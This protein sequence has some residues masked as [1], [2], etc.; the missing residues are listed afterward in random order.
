MNYQSMTKAQLIAHL[1]KITA[2][3]EYSHV[4]AYKGYQ[5]GSNRDKFLIFFEK[6][7][8]G[9]LFLNKDGIITAVN[10]AALEIFGLEIDEIVGSTLLD[11]RWKVIH[12]DGSEFS[13]KEQPS[14]IALNTGREV[15]NVVAGVLNSNKKET[16]WI[17]M[18]AIPIY[19][20]DNEKPDEVF[21]TLHDITDH[22]S[23]NLKM[24]ENEERFRTF[25]EVSLD[26]LWATDAEGNNTY[27]SPSWCA[28]TSISEREAR[29]AGWSTGIHPEDRD[30]IFA[31]W[32][33][34][35]QNDQPYV[36][37]FR[38]VHPNGR[39]VW[40][41]CQARSIK[42]ANGSI[43]EWVGTITD[44][45]ERKQAEEKIK[46]N[47]E[48][49]ELLLDT[50]PECVAVLDEN[51]KIVRVNDAWKKFTD[52][53]E[54]PK[55]SHYYIGREYC[56]SKMLNS[57][58]GCE[59]DISKVEN[60]LK[61]LVNG[62][63]DQFTMEYPCHSPNEKR[64]FEMRAVP[65][66]SLK[67]DSREQ[68]VKG[69]LVMHINITNIK[70]AEIALMQSAALLD[71]TEKLSKVGGW[72]WNIDEQKM[73]WTEEVYHIHGMKSTDLQPGSNEHINR[74]IECYMPDDRKII[75]DA[76][77][78]CAEEGT[79]YDLEVPFTTVGGEK[80]W[81]RTTAQAV[82]EKGKIARVIGNI[83]DITDR[84]MTENALRDSEERLRLFIDHAP[85]ALAMF[86]PEMCYLAASKR[87]ISDYNLSE[88]D[89]IGKS[90]YELFP[91]IGDEWKSVHKR[92]L[93]GIIVTAEEDKFLLE[94]G[95]VQWLRWEVRPW[96]RADETV[97]GIVIF[98]E[99]IT[100]NI[101]SK[102][103]MASRL[104]LI[105]FA[106]NHT[107][108]ELLEETLNET[109][110]LTGSNIG[111]YHFVEKDQLSLTLQNWST[112][113]KEKFCKAESKGL[114][115]NID[116]AGVW[117]D[118][119]YQR[120]PVIH[121]DYAALNHKKGMPSGH[122]EVI[123][124]LVV[125]VLRGDKIAAI[126][127]VGNK[128]QDY[129]QKDVDIVALIADMAWDIVER[130][131]IEEVL[132]IS[133]DNLYTFFNTVDEFLFILDEEY[134]IIEFNETVGKRLGYSR[135]ELIGK[136][137][138]KVHPENRHKEAVEIVTAMLAGKRTS[139]P[140]PLV[141]KSGELIPVE[142]SVKLGKW[143]GSPA[144]F[145]A[146]KDI[147][148]LK[149]SEE[150]FATAFHSN[151]AIA[152]LSDMETGVY[153]E[154]NQTFYDKL[155]FS[156]DEVIGRRASEVVRLDIKFRDRTISKLKKNNFVNNEEAVIYAKDGTPID[157][158]L[159]A[160]II[161]LQG[162]R[163]NYTAAVDISERKKSELALRE[164]EARFRAIFKSVNEGIIYYNK[165]GTVLYVNETLEKITGI[166][167]DDLIG[168]NALSL[169]KK[170]V[171]KNQRLL[172]LKKLGSVLRGSSI[173]PFELEF[174]DKILEISTFYI[175]DTKHLTTIIRDI[176]EQKKYEI[177]IR[178]RE[179]NYRQV[180]NT[181]QETL[182]VISLDGS[183]LFANSNA[184]LNLS[185]D[186]P[187]TVIGKNISDF[188]PKSQSD[189][190]IAQY[191]QVYETGQSLT[192]DI[193][194]DIKKGTT[195]FYN[196]LKPIEYGMD[197]IPAILSVS[198]DITKE[199]LAEK[200]LRESEEKFRT[201]F[202]NANI[203]IALSDENGVLIE[204]NREFCAM[205]G[206]ECD[207]LRGRNVLEI[208]HPDDRVFE[209]NVF[210]KPVDKR[211]N[212]H[213]FIKR[214]LTRQNTI[215]WVDLS[216]F[217][218]YRDPENS[219]FIFAGMALDITDRVLA[220]QALRESEYRY[221]L[222]MMASTD[223]IYDWDLKTNQVYYSP[224][225]KRMLGYG[226]EEIR[227]ELSEWERLT[228]P[229]DVPRTYRM[230]EE[231]FSG[232]RDRAEIE[233]RM[234]HK[235]GHWVDI[236]TR[237]SAVFDE[238]GKPIRQVGTHL[239]ISGRKR[240]E[241]ALRRSELQYRQLFDE[242][243]T[244]F[245]LHEIICD[246][247]GKPIDY[248]YLSINRAAE[249][250]IGLKA[251]ELVNKR[252]LE[253]FPDMNPRMIDLLGKVALTGEGIEYQDHAIKED[254]YFDVRAF[255][256]EHG[257]FAII[258]ND[259]TDR[260]K[261]L[262]VLNEREAQL[263]MAVNMAKLGY[264]EY[265]VAENLFKFNDNF[266]KI[267][268]TSANEAGG[269]T[270]SP[271]EY[272]ERFM[273]PDDG[274]IVADET[275]KAIE[276]E[277]ADYSRSLEHRFL[278]ADGGIGYL[279][280]LFFV[281][282]DED[283]KTIKT[284]GVNQDI[285]DR[286]RAELALV[287]NE[288]KITTLIS[289]L[290]GMAYTCLNEKTWTMSFISEG[291]LA[292]TGY[293]PDEIIN[294]SSLSY[295]DLI[296]EEDRERIWDEVQAAL[297]HRKHFFLEYRI[298]TKSG[299]IKN[300]WEGGIGVFNN[301]GE[302]DALEGFIMDITPR[303]EMQ[304][305]LIESENRLRILFEMMV[306]GVVYHDADGKIIWANPAAEKILGVSLRTMQG[307]T[308]MD[309]QFNVIKEDGL[310]FPG[311]THPAMV[312]LRTGKPQNNV[313]MGVYNQNEE[314]YHWIDVSSMPLILPG[315]DKPYQVFATFTDITERLEAQQK[316]KYLNTAIE[317][318]T[319]S[320]VITETNGY[321][322]YCNPAVSRT[323]GYDKDELIGQHTRIFKSGKQNLE[324]YK[325]LWDIITN[326][327]TWSGHL[328]NKRK[329]GQFYHE[330]AVISP[331]HSPLGEIIGY[332]ALKRDVTR[333]VELEEQILQSQKLETLGILAGGIAHDFNNLLTLINGYSEFIMDR[334]GPGDPFYKQIQH[335]NNAGHRAARLTSQLLAFSRKQVIEPQI[336][337]LH[338]EIDG[339]RKILQRIIGEDIQ[340]E[341]HMNA[342][343]PYIKMDPGQLEQIIMN[344]SVNA[345]DAMQ[346]GGVFTIATSD[347]S[348]GD[349]EMAQF[350]GVQPGNYI[351]FSFSDTGVG[352]D[353]EIQKKIFE[354][355]FTTKGVGKGTGLGLAMV[356]GIVMQNN[357]QI[358]VVSKPGAGTTFH[359]YLPKIE[360]TDSVKSALLR[361]GVQYTY[362]ATILLVED[363]IGIRG[364]MY[365]VISEAGM[366]VQESSNPLDALHI[367]ERDPYKFDL[368]VTDIIMPEMTG[369]ELSEKCRAIRPDLK[370]L[371]MSGYTDAVLRL[372]EKMREHYS[373]IQK[374]FVTKEFIR[375]IIET[376][377][378]E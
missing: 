181:M 376:I 149:V 377:K 118:C 113:T 86:D 248:R 153:V 116:Q 308:S 339:I 366:E 142:T 226:E 273:H 289:N 336:L 77:R 199:R 157:V 178:Q 45:S 190:L 202:E 342:V 369:I 305:R 374:P 296:V 350:I 188:L 211:I 131:R 17:S 126:L 261:A 357:G 272:V 111:F 315:Q 345:R 282:K 179:E 237:S 293:E 246:A 278:Y 313:L 123:R 14:L 138:L 328:I 81:I 171:P 325:N 285:T 182:S 167:M 276:C 306:Q 66:H 204:N 205:L 136:S 15:K 280:V 49:S 292:L 301:S 229:D 322:T 61:A 312:S 187:E 337:D 67:I 84:K 29:G 74:S 163:Y 40:V 4:P 13:V 26:G 218:I 173:K 133:R 39:I 141:T 186:G 283:G 267:F 221:N 255:C 21:V 355:F 16:V 344:I 368:L 42:N 172:V 217:P 208:T 6:M 242:M 97:G 311:D 52:A 239:D 60:G 319:E 47:L 359:I 270:M 110:K 375:K 334:S 174:K 57:K 279:S 137:V 290:P 338:T 240:M 332:V 38:F 353:R 189:R 373:F 232:K 327:R 129:T 1:N 304:N 63:L 348:S 175:R 30:A 196:T 347:V 352:M 115:Y 228:H 351:R 166:A 65:L 314:K 197:N 231:Y 99:D 200:A 225:W 367:F 252:A 321:I 132:Q 223:G 256:P 212:S 269:Y 260:V 89:L 262:R 254:K 150:K 193:A 51:R 302:V 177:T 243:I 152:G 36:S 222:A 370:V 101:R 117:V 162:K 7:A 198:L 2:E 12:E 241:E 318:A 194:L 244:G 18:D 310:E 125:P 43:K 192:Q 35:A 54:L 95:S 371:L 372:D 11:P 20:N 103:L 25:V 297:M 46:Q 287:E 28:L 58:D 203:G 176:S 365:N 316:M 50:L 73:F 253:I 119:V 156:P 277:S 258:F 274:Y 216:V 329:E 343:N 90:H 266:Y 184:A 378:T 323:S 286:R 299:E 27:V 324:F 124:E 303:V 56:C 183:F 300:V 210:D 331:I 335:I 263:S 358:G 94:D 34:S 207:E 55:D 326:G 130:K 151:P 275:K 44:I 8:Q 5:S 251:S 41:Y 48:F 209:A 354:P 92:G 22:R 145:G 294:N 64:W 191:R 265:N 69:T 105:E 363:D 85:L 70:K 233:I 147:S 219:R 169:A 62:S 362:S 79:C 158:L 247:A 144:L 82:R 78:K 160:E 268:H 206:Y 257:K 31:G 10:N 114:H 155:G 349:A 71:S 213:R 87:W 88:T 259:V 135:A 108:D 220:E 333:E 96:N 19:Y 33:Q 195:W 168:K 98:T 161:V 317:Q 298:R 227:N 83:A 72:E 128:T 320:I 32:K 224:A 75:M 180:T 102:E 236:L 234:K 107:V 154:V 24:A 109:E 134:N 264:W 23:S 284:Y 146:S 76:F 235:D 249:R 215:K 170:M 9:A 356:Y 3:A 288:R 59:E 121:N 37:E 307:R 143:N 238:N 139:C 364:L 104:H 361:R 91:E 330:E 165:A 112:N 309:P 159:S 106:E 346:N 127:G 122:A 295:N 140:V 68:H 214:Y 281:V 245:A 230:L 148:D 340:F 250:L 80:K 201:L 291:S 53:N 341:V 360:E 120:K 185:G 93:E 100:E 271:K 164:N